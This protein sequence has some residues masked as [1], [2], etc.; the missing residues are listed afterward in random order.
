MRSRKASLRRGMALLEAIVALTI[1]AVGATT[2]V[3]LAAA[4]LGAV[5]RANDA[6]AETRRADALLEAVSLWP[7]ADL[8]RHLGDRMEGPWD[9]RVDRPS[10]TLYVVAL[11]DTTNHAVLLSTSLYRAE[12]PHA[13]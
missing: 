11:R 1:L 9:L 13:P 10:P 8:D 7:R 5:S 4:S 12:P 6:D 3:A 2:M